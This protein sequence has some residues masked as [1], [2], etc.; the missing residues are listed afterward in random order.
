MTTT[1]RAP[2]E[3]G[4][5]G[6]GVPAVLGRARDLIR[7]AMAAVVET[8]EPEVR[9]VAM[10]HLGFVDRHGRPEEADRGKAVRPAL[11][12]LSAEAVG[13]GPHVALPGALAVELVHDFSL[14]HDDVMD[15]DVERRHRATAWTVFGE[16][17]AI[18][19]GDALHALAGEILL[20]LGT[21]QG[22]RAASALSRATARMIA[23][24]AQDLSFAQRPDVSVEECL[25][26]CANKTG[27]LLS[28]ASS[29]GA[30]LAGAPDLR[31]RALER[32]G[33]ELG[34]AFQAMDDILGIWGRPSVTGKPA[35]G[36]L[37]ERKKTLPVVAALA[38]PAGPHRDRL[39]ELLSRPHL[40]EAEIEAAAGL[41]EVCGGRAWASEEARR[42]LSSAVAA[43][44]GR[45]FEPSA[46]E[47]LTELAAFVAAREF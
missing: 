10:Y 36:D 23:G 13:A 42:R 35:A 32:F 34:L 20:E 33:R 16:A 6:G 18:V 37:R 12:V 43:L 24:Q 7:P 21:A 26:M 39:A 27:A 9:R 41:V 47:R 19:A 5:R 8:L 38:S 15:R 29:L 31:V 46:V 4:T 30:I 17:R 1:T 11:V 28:C 3:P 40:A 25:A 2:G 44:D 22:L 14:L 45:G